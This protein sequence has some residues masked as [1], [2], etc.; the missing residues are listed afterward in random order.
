MNSSHDGYPMPFLALPLAR[1]P[2]TTTANPE[3]WA[4]VLEQLEKKF[5]FH[6]LDVW[7][8]ERGDD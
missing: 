8:G 1:Y 6:H 7:T 4:K 2:E 3:G 5:G